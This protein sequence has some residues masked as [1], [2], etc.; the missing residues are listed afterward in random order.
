MTQAQLAK[1]MVIARQNVASLETAE[2]NGNVTLSRL[3]RAAEK[4]GCELQYVLVPKQPL[5]EMVAN[6]ARHRAE[7]KLG[8]INRSQALEA[9]AM[10]ANSLS[11]TVTDLARELEMNRPADLWDE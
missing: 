2:L 7:Q 9:A 10:S 6:Q 11:N 8:R 1:R 3:S 5:E 4:L